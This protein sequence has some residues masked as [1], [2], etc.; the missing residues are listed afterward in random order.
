VVLA[1]TGRGDS[2]VLATFLTRER[3]LVSA[4]AKNARQSV[5]RFGGGLLSPGA[6][7]WYHFRH[8]PG[9]PVGLVERA[10][11]NPR[12]PS[13]PLDP[14]ARAL[15][16]WPL[17]LARSF[18]ARD[19]PAT[20]SFNLVLR[21]LS[22]LCS[23]GDYRPPALR[24]RSLSLAFT[25]LYL[26]LAGFGPD[27]GGCLSCGRTE[28][29][30]WRLDPAAPGL[31]CPACAGAAPAHGDAAELAA[32]MRALKSLRD[33]PALGEA[34]LRLAELFHRRLATIAAGRTFKSPRVLQELLDE[35]PPEGAAPEG[36]APSGHASEGGPPD[37]D[38]PDG[39]VPDAAPDQAQDQ[40][41]DPARD[42][43]AGPAAGP[44]AAG[45]AT[46]D[47]GVDPAGRAGRGDR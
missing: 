27:W 30:A 35:S 41:Q 42:P 1:R 16:A 7:A 2:D 20:E 45:A 15:A 23:L 19:N 10:E 8:R 37:G 28:A 9:S 4:L 26:E 21:H 22:A 12:A 39:G 38:A 14:V 3:G 6:V 25:K 44:D 47:P 24:A 36:D 46:Q 43:A 40:A 32:A 33:A 17:E 11:A 34:P 13:I 18:E 31:F 5:R 29:P